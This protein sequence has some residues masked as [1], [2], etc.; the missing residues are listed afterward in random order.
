MDVTNVEASQSSLL[1]VVASTRIVE[2]QVVLS[3]EGCA[4]FVAPLYQSQPAQHEF[5]VRVIRGRCA[6]SLFMF[7]DPRLLPHF[8]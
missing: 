6:N 3:S 4:S 8:L 1:P 5:V 7:P 2:P